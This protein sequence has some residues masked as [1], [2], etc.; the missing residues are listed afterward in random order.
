[1]SKSRLRTMRR[2]ALM[3]TGTSSK[4]NL[5]ER[6][7][8]LPSRSGSVCPRMTSAVLSF[9]VETCGWILVIPLIARQHRPPVAALSSVALD[10]HNAAGRRGPGF[11]ITAGTLF[12]ELVTA[13]RIL[14]R[15]GHADSA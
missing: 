10:I 3:I 14:A 9:R 6:G 8:T 12:A 15:Q 5:K 7:F 13:H 1:M 4:S 2:N 11:D